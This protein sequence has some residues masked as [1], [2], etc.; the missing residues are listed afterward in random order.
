[1]SDVFGLGIIGCGDFLRWQQNDILDSTRVKTVALY[2]TQP[3]R[4]RKY[5]EKLG[6]RVAASVDEILDDPEISVVCLFVPPW[7]RAGLVARTAKAGK[8]I[9]T[10]KPL[11]AKVD[12]ATAMVKAVHDAGIKCTVFYRRTGMIEID[13]LRDLFIQ[14]DIGKLGMFKEDWFHHYPT[15]NDWATDP[16]RNGGPFM[17]A[18]VH[19]LNIA[20]YLAHRDVAAVTFFSDNHAQ[21][22]KC[23]DTEM[24]KVDFEGG[25][26]AYLFITWAGDLKV[27]S[28]EGN[29]REHVDYTT[30]ISDQ[31]WNISFGKGDSGRMIKACKDD[32]ERTF[33]IPPASGTPFDR[34]IAA[35]ESG[36]EI[37]WDI[38]DAWKDIKLLDVATRHVGVQC[39]PDLTPPV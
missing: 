32:E 17:D 1:M 3:E 13:A 10:T 4:A 34:F 38:I 25:A 20:R 23:N 31:G 14:G 22:L 12:E 21:K 19:N 27:F 26:S 7:V 11:A 29:D 2:D 39:S 36:S 8:H 6:G 28:N 35:V 33:P 18:M 37:P 5:A 9:I 24:M 16:E 30:I 15:W